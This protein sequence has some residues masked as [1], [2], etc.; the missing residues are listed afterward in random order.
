MLDVLVTC[1]ALDEGFDYPEINAALILSASTTTRQRIQRMGR[2]LRTTKAEK[3]AMI[4]SIYSSD[5]EFDRL[6]LESKRF[7]EEGITV[8]WTSLI[9][10]K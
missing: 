5:S 7:I 6:T 2:V 3:N 9:F 1:K 4:I 8:N 10:K